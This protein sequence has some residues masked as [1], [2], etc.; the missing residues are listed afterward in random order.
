MNVPILRGLIE[1]RLLVNYRVDP[2]VASRLLPKPFTPKLVGG[3]ALAGICLIRLGQVRPRGLPPWVGIRSENAAHRIAVVW[4]DGDR[5]REGVYIPRRDSNSWINRLAGGRI[6]PGE[7]HA[8]S[9]HVDENTDRYCVDMR[10]ND[11]LTSVRVAGRRAETMP[12]GSV[13]GSVEEASRF[14]E[15]GSVGYSDTSLPNQYDGL[16]LRAFRWQVE[17]LDVTD[18]ASSFFEDGSRFPAKSA[19]FDSALLMRDIEHE[20]HAREAIV[21]TA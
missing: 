13:F 6:F 8:A 2:E 15:G 14:F 10:S 18:V 3:Y 17:P 5:A 9:F 12:S 11:G 1:R 20:W 16:E 7:H 21:S 4:S 19:E